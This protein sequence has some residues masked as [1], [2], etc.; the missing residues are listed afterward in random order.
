[1]WCIQCRIKG[2][3]RVLRFRSLLGTQFAGKN[4]YMLG[5]TITKSS[6]N[7]ATDINTNLH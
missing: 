4:F 7:A 5:D 1:M 3:P 6:R 2:M